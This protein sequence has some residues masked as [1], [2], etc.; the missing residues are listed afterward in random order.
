M[1]KKTTPRRSAGS[2]L[3]LVP[4]APGKPR[5]RAAAALSPIVRNTLQDQAYQKLRE[6]LM[7]G[8]IKPGESLTLRATA[9]V[10]GT[11]PMPVRDA[12][13]RLEIEH[14]LEPRPNRTLGVPE[15]TSASLL[16]LRDIRI[17]LEGLAAEKAALLIEAPE[18][19]KVDAHYRELAA[20][21]EAGNHA[22]YLRANWAFHSAIYRASRSQH[23]V[24]LIEPTWIRIGPYVG[25]MLPDRR[26]LVDSLENHLQALRALRQRDAAAA[27]QAIGQ[28]IWDSAE[29]L[30]RVLREREARAEKESTKETPPSQ[31]RSLSGQKR[32]RTHE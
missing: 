21:A 17:A 9:E 11:S 1:P 27:R 22:D 14:A 7:S 2:S 18:L 13:R 20:A 30:V 31:R 15:M 23:L 10:M 12:V 29:G 25:L 26:N 16:E 5:A 32:L 3:R 24:S 28:D 8:V 6:A 19:E 4:K